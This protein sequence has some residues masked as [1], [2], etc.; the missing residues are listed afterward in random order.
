MRGDEVQEGIRSMANT[1]TER[2]ASIENPSTVFADLIGV[3]IWLTFAVIFIFVPPLNESVLRILFALPTILF[4]P[5]YVLIAA[6]FPGS[7]D[8]DGI[9]RVALSFG[10][11][12]AVVPLTGLAL[13]YTPWGIRLEPVVASIV[14]LTLI[15]T[16]VGAVRRAGIP[17]DKRFTIPFREGI[18]EAQTALAPSGG[19]WVDRV[20]NVVLLL[21]I[22]VA[23]G[24]TIY[25][26]MVPKEGEHFTEFYILGPQGKAADYPRELQSGGSYSVI[27]GI[28]NH[29]YRNIT[30][31][32][33][34]DAVNMS[35]DP[36][37]NLSI[38]DAMVTLDRF[39]VVLSHNTTQEI[40]WN[41]TAPPAGYNRLEFL[42][43]NETVPDDG[44]RSMDRINASYR[45]LHLWVTVLQPIPS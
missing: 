40:P 34:I 38:L 41:F 11:S 35:F 7:E 21:S 43:F 28:G 29:E 26:I 39:P 33:E 37:T 5:G 18:R 16:L 17:P 8:L 13:N 36:A 15:L 23:V 6:L 12:I 44:V 22:V 24:A 1:L 32:V 31:M 4:I 42:L 14:G 25:V 3:V 45:D 19:T 9:E 20:L 30:Y 2:L 27:I 10:L